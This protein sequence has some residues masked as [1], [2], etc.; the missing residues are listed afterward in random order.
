MTSFPALSAL[1]SILSSIRL[2]EFEVHQSATMTLESIEVVMA[3][4]FPEE[5]DNCFAIVALNREACSDPPPFL[6]VLP[7]RMMSDPITSV[8]RFESNFVAGSHSEGAA[9]LDGNR[10]L[11]FA[12][13]CGQHGVRR[14]GFRRS[15]HGSASLRISFILL[16]F[17][18]RRTP[19][20]SCGVDLPVQ[21]EGQHDQAGQEGGEQKRKGDEAVHENQAGSFGTLFG[22]RIRLRVFR[23]TIF[24]LQFISIPLYSYFNASTG[25]ICAARVAGAVPKMTPTSVAATRATTMEMPEMGRL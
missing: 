12:G 18:M 7:S 14:P 3:A 25:S 2:R 24:R 22:L 6:E 11:T 23:F 1:V 9:N 21:I 20:K 10:D 15:R 13:D 19:G 17:S 16:T 4:H 5:C 8:K